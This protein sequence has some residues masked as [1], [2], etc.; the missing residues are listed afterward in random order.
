MNLLEAGA[1]INR[2]YVTEVISRVR[3]SNERLHWSIGRGEA[4]CIGKAV[5]RQQSRDGIHELKLDPSR[6]TVE[7]PDKSHD[8]DLNHG[9]VIDSANAHSISKPYEVRQGYSLLLDREKCACNTWPSLVRRLYVTC[10]IF[11]CI[12]RETWQFFRRS[13]AHEMIHQENRVVYLL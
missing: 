8:S 13:H 12:I 5:V 6:Q 10:R 7:G 9:I 11:S 4:N 2:Y 1:E 3:I